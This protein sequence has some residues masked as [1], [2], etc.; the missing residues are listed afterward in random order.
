[1][2][3]IDAAKT[4]TALLDRSDWGCL[5]VADADRLR[6]LHNQT[7]NEMQSLQPGQG[8]RTVFVTSTA[9]TMDVVSAYVRDDDVLLL[10]SPG[11]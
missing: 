2:K 5:R 4:A 10:T 1:M 3:G 9:R 6:F 7:T 11:M 8:C